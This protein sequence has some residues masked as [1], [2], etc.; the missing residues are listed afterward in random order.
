[1][2]QRPAAWVPSGLRWTTAGPM[3]NWCHLGD[4]RFTA[5]FFEQT[6]GQAM[7]HPFNLL[8]GHS[9]PLAEVAARAGEAPEL[10]LS[11]FIFHMS[12]CG[13]TVVSQMLAALPCNVVLSE[14]APLDQ[15]LRIPDRIAG[16]P[17]DEL[18]RCLRGMVA[19]LGRRRHADEQNLFVKF[20]AWH[21]LRL[22]L[23]RR[24]FPHVPWIFLYRDPIEVLA[25]L[26]LSRPSQMFGST[27]PTLLGRHAAEL[28]ALTPDEFSALVLD[29]YLSAAMEH[30]RDGG[31]LVEYRELPEAVC[32]KMLDHFGLRYGEPEIAAMRA[33]AQVDAKRPG[34]PFT[35]DGEMKRS[36]ANDEL[37]QLADDLAPLHARLEE[38]RKSSDR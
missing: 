32:G 35:P 27:N 25:S 7:K 31:L 15:I 18:A 20:D 2:R 9:T 37:R 10:A 5:P 17:E 33:A 24:A 4:L 34:K 6:I 22:P 28:A 11:G 30:H 21:V 12:R 14:P 29:R 8:F 1:M 3:V 38:L 19:A 13:S 36:H 16:V 26:A 23:L